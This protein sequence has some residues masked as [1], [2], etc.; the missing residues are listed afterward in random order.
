M[1]HFFAYFELP[2]S[3]CADYACFS[4]VGKFIVPEPIFFDNLRINFQQKLIQGAIVSDFS[5]QAN[6]D[7]FAKNH[8]Q[9]NALLQ[10]TLL[11]FLNQRLAFPCIQAHLT[12]FIMGND[13]DK[14]R[15]LTFD[16]DV[17]T[18]KIGENSNVDFSIFQQDFI[19]HLTK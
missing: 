9:N 18:A 15:I 13:F 6:N 5:K 12:S 8:K 3:T 17:I 10:T 16:K 7:Y 14:N 19:F 2:N 1:S 4:Q 11:N